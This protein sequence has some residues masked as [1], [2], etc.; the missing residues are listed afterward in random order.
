MT[1]LHDMEEK[2]ERQRKE[3][4]SAKQDNETLQAQLL[5]L[6]AMVGFIVILKRYHHL[7]KIGKYCL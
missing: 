4:T 1:A 6:R 2:Q 3:L 5:E 7:V